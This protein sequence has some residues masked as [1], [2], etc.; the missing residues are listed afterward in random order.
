M[1]GVLFLQ[2]RGSQFFLI[3]ESAPCGWG[4][5]VCEGF[6]VGKLLSVFW[7][8]DLG[9]SLESNAV[10]SNEFGVSMNLV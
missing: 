4:W 6:L 1:F 3:L 10:S 8:M 7:W 5:K 9:L 2:A